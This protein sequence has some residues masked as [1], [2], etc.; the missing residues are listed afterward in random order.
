[1]VYSAKYFET[2]F[3]GDSSIYLN[4]CYDK[5]KEKGALTLLKSIDGFLHSRHYCYVSVTSYSSYSDEPSL[6]GGYSLL[7]LVSPLI[8]KLIVDEIVKNIGQKNASFNFLDFLIG[9]SF[10][11]NIIGVF[12]TTISD[13]LG[14]YL[15][16]KLRK[17]LTEKFYYKVLGLPQDYFDSAISGKIVNQL[18]RGIEIIQDF[19]NTSTNFILPSILS[20]IPAQVWR[21]PLLLPHQQNCW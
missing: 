2:S 20:S 7:G 15:A 11:V 17:F 3:V 16:G 14:D 1:M 4:R 21:Y 18:N 9:L 12:F 6:H 10:F 13:R 5:E 19:A 8:S